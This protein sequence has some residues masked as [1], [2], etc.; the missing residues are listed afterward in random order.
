[1][2][3]LRPPEAI[4]TE[5][6]SL[7]KEKDVPQLP[8]MTMIHPI[9]TEQGTQVKGSS[10]I[11]CTVIQG[12]P[13]HCLPFCIRHFFFILNTNYNTLWF[14][15]AVLNKRYVYVLLRST[16]CVLSC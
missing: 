15:F 10:T 11:I 1:M 14:V 16:R 2:G 6:D 13:L 5:N 7:P 12:L 8:K 9:D 3:Y 4:R